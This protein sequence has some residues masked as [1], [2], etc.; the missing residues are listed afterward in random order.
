MHVIM[1]IQVYS[2]TFTPQVKCMN[3]VRERVAQIRTSQVSTI[4]TV[5]TEHI[6]IPKYWSNS[7]ESYMNKFI[8]IYMYKGRSQRIGGYGIN[9]SSTFALQIK[10]NDFNVS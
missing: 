2:K 5:A 3:S 10:F 7:F 1:G 9:S 4:K 6:F 8:Y